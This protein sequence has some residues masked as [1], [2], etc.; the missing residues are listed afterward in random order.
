M[1]NYRIKVLNLLFEL[2]IILDYPSS[3][4]LKDMISDR[5]ILFTKK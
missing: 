2:V 4:V 5:K 1:Y 3:N